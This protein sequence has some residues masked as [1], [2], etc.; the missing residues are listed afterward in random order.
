MGYVQTFD[1]TFEEH[2]NGAGPAARGEVHI[3]NPPPPPLLEIDPGVTTQGT[4]ST[5]DGTAV[6]HGE[7]TCTKVTPMEVG[8]P[9]TEVAKRTTTVTGAFRSRWTTR[10]AFITGGG[11]FSYV[12]GHD[13]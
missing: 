7:A 12:A 8:G 13:A 10:R 3:A 2:C 1:A 5:V 9:V 6:I 4:A 11:S